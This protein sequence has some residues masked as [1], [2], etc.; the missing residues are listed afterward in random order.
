MDRKGFPESY[1][2]RRLLRFL[3]DVKGGQEE[4]SAPIYSHVVY[5]IVPDGEQIIRRPDILIL[6]GLNVLQ[7]GESAL[8]VSDFFDLSIYVDALEADIEQ[9]Y[10]DRFLALRETAFTDATSFFRHFATLRD[11]EAVMMARGIWRTINGLNLADNI[12]PTRER[13]DLILEKGADHAIRRVRLR[14]R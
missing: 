9:W 7:G 8:A 3:A 14:F 2:V 11:D 12:L 13:A 4:V 10:V 6:E 1:D 5:D